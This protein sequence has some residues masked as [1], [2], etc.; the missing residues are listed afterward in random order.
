M[1]GLDQQGFWLLTAQLSY[2]QMLLLQTI[3][4]MSHSKPASKSKSRKSNP[5]YITERH[6]VLDGEAIVLRTKQSKDV[7]Q[8]RMRVQGEGAYYRESLRTKHLQTAIARAKNKWADITAMVNAGKKVFSITVAEMVQIYLGHR[9][10]HVELGLLSKGRHYI[11]S[12]H[13]KHLTRLLGAGTRVNDMD[14][15]SLQDYAFIRRSEKSGI[16]NATINNEQ[17]TINACFK[18]CYDEGFV[19]IQKLRFEVLPIQDS[20]DR[21]ARA[22]FTPKQFQKLK[23]VML[24]YVLERN[25]S[26]DVR[27]LRQMVR[28]FILI[29]AKTM[30]RFGELRQLQWRSVSDSFTRVDN[31]GVQHS[32]V[33]IT[34]LADTSK[35]RKTRNVIAKAGIKHQH[36]SQGLHLSNCNFDCEALS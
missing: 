7:W 10:R 22:T 28:L 15:R 2:K 11:I 32:L 34:V 3:K 27:V 29:S 31:N 9:Q 4:A 26:P 14:K 13:L 17:A 8:F 24:E 19:H 5:T 23:D 30:M 33:K 12:C 35:V 16:K 36:I 25:I 21:R 20:V 1:Q 6:E 18:Y